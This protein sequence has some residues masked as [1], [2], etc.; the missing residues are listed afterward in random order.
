MAAAPLRSCCMSLY[1]FIGVSTTVI[2]HFYVYF[3]LQQFSWQLEFKCLLY[4]LLFRLVIV[5]RFLRFLLREIG[6]D[7]DG[8]L[9]DIIVSMDSIAAKIGARKAKCTAASSLR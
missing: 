2:I 3:S 5:F 4:L 6:V 1:V 7:L 9:H 8:D